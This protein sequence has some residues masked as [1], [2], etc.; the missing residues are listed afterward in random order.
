M[1]YFL[2]RTI[3]NH[4]KLTGPLPSAFRRLRKLRTVGLYQNSLSGACVSPPASSSCML[5]VVWRPF[6]H[7]VLV[8]SVSHDAKAILHSSVFVGISARQLCSS[9]FAGALPDLFLTD[10][11]A[12][13]E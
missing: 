7:M 2:Y 9:C 13:T 5:T 1:C 10:S 12:C 6:F 4:P 11:M 8:D 3:A